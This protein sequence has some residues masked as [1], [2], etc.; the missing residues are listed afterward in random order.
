MISRDILVS[1]VLN[2]TS[3]VTL[4][5]RGGAKGCLRGVKKTFGLGCTIEKSNG[6]ELDYFIKFKVEDDDRVFVDEE[7]LL[8]YIKK[9]LTKNHLFIKL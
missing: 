4:P 1:N 9:G 8:N 2:N 7:S 5:I 3:T 6:N